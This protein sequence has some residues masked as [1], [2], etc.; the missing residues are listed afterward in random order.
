M[1]PF[2]SFLKNIPWYRHF[3]AIYQGLPVVRSR[4]GRISQVPSEE[5]A[6]RQVYACSFV[7]AAL[8]Q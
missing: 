3:N 8:Q 5:P 6:G 4:N 2:F 1:R 7:F